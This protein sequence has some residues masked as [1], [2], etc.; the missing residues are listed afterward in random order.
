MADSEQQLG[1]HAQDGPSSGHDVPADDRC[2][3]QP[4]NAAVSNIRS[5]RRRTKTGCLTCRKRRIKC[6]EER[7]ICNNC[8]KS[9]RSCEGYN[10]RVI[11]KDPINAF[12]VAGCLAPQGSINGA[13]VHG[14]VSPTAVFQ[15]YNHSQSASSA[16]QAP[17]PTIAPK[18]IYHHE[19]RPTEGVQEQA[20]TRPEQ[21][22]LFVEQNGVTQAPPK[23]RPGDLPPRMRNSYQKDPTPP[24]TSFIGGGEGGTSNS[25]SDREVH[26]IPQLGSELPKHAAQGEE[27]RQDQMQETWVYSS[28]RS[29]GLPT[30]LA[31]TPSAFFF[32][33]STHR[34]VPPPFGAAESHHGLSDAHRI[35]T[36]QPAISKDDWLV[37]DPEHYREAQS[38]N[39][40]RQLAVNQSSRFH[41]WR[42]GVVPIDTEAHSS[43][44]LH[45]A[46]NL[47]QAPPLLKQPFTETITPLEE[48]PDGEE[49]DDYY[50]VDSD[51]MEVDQDNPLALAERPQEDLELILAVHARTDDG[52]QRAVTT[53]V[54]HT[55]VLAHYRPA[56]T[57]SPLLNAKTARIFCHFVTVTGPSISM[58]ERHPTNP[59]IMF[60]GAPVPRSHQSLWTYALP[61]MALG[62]QGL[63]HAM[64]ALASLHLAK[65]L[66]GS[67]GPS[68]KHYHYSLRRISKALGMPS[69]RN[70]I[71]TLAASLLLGY[72]EVMSAEHNK[73][74]SHLRGAT[75]LI[76]EIDFA[77]PTR[78]L[79]AQ[80]AQQETSRMRQM[81][82]A[83]DGFLADHI[84][85][86]G[87]AYQTSELND[88]LATDERLVSTLMG[89]R[90]RYDE[91][92]Q[93][94][95]HSRYQKP[96]TSNF[97]TKDM[98]I[99]ETRRDLYWWY[100]KHD[101][102]S[103]MISGNRLL[104]DYE[105]WGDCPPRSRIGRLDALFGTW[106]HL[107]LLVA[108][109]ADFAAKDQPRKVRA[110]AASGGAWR[111]APWMN[112]GPP[113]SIPPQQPG[114]SLPN[115]P[116][117]RTPSQSVHPATVG[118]S[119]IP[120]QQQSSPHGAIPPTTPISQ[121][122]GFSNNSTSFS[123]PKQQYDLDL[124][125]A[126][127]EAE[128]EWKEIKAA[129]R[130]FEDCLGPDF[131]PLS[132]EY[133]QPLTTPFGPALYYRTYSVACIWVLYYTG[134]I[135]IERAHPAM[136]PA[137][138]QAAG[139][140]ARQTARYANEIGRTCAGLGPT[141]ANTPLNPSL[142][143]AL[144]ESTMGL[145]FA[146][147]Q[148]QDPAQRGWIVSRLLDITRRTGWGSSETVAAGCE[149]AWQKMAERGK[150]PPYQRTMNRSTRDD[151]V[152]G[153]TPSTGE[154]PKDNSD[155][156]FVT[157][158]P[159][160]RVH[161][162]MGL[163]A[164]EED[165]QK[166]SMG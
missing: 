7:P 145:F 119:N 50:D 101:L 137:M 159:N 4:T 23:Y 60:T 133:M 113:P 69:R 100:C 162:A 2:S 58:Y 164:L 41:G 115:A 157:V 93:V 77:G 142:A 17:L 66:G 127:V 103:S 135:L 29:H 79:K 91:H 128:E 61:T 144:M 70:D 108:R 110:V 130:V 26:S 114:G 125:A 148:I 149:T 154:P 12:R 112:L 99:Y 153:N 13:R 54:D 33:P 44:K 140:A 102:Y 126:T 20:Q 67:L 15:Q 124:E 111:P 82:R 3:Q 80:R 19:H 118:Q 122:S 86:G 95:D 92:G 136:P 150:G 39:G 151:R 156:R 22:A 84:L 52:R 31:D 105:R 28:L 116:T 96:A 46:R 98:E 21:S 38:D 6:G 163:L 34:A 16:N 71:T 152:S 49:S 88:E 36:H 155:R 75:H 1:S 147:V 51:D 24:N 123:P 87:Q 59:S 43:L 30:P 141:S 25:V 35:A 109:V 94:I 132:P 134:L 160:A 81:S 90:V 45:N 11:F 74:S 117:D 40:S 5:S 76:K 143:A 146:G 32:P 63:L 56:M 37:V 62:N 161:W 8:V 42:D 18:P 104:L 27:H 120:A 129:F 83:G 158:D 107:L 64:L 14:L 72:Y 106:D 85:S 73:W 78:Q 9:K 138:F 139:V 55:N 48:F 166:L 68:M 165:I 53:L 47:E 131:K 97:T 65:I 10:N 57:A 121:P 89:R